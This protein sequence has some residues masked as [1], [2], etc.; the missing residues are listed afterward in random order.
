MATRSRLL[1][2][3]QARCRPCVLQTSETPCSKIQA[4]DLVQLID[5]PSP[6]PV[7]RTPPHLPLFFLRRRSPPPVSPASPS[8]PLFSSTHI[9][10]APPSFPD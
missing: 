10:Q 9:P 5:A 8:V 2:S 3:H 6:L 4:R 1:A 7:S